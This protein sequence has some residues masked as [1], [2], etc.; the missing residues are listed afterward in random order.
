MFSVMYDNGACLI[1]FYFDGTYTQT[2]HVL[3]I[4]LPWTV[5]PLLSY[6]TYT[7]SHHQ[8]ATPS[9]L[10][11]SFHFL[12]LNKYI[13][14]TDCTHCKSTEICTTPESMSWQSRCLNY[15]PTQVKQPHSLTR[16]HTHIIVHLAQQVWTN[17]QPD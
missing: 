2:N 10:T 13:Y 17:W 12:T 16:L 8:Q 5:T 3:L 11:T 6:S 14:H 15:W 4:T 9:A 1:M 7:Y